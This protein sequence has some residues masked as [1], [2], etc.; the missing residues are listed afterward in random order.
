M[1][2]IPELSG[3]TLKEAAELH[4]LLELINTKLARI[5]QL[6]WENIAFGM[7]H[8]HSKE[9]ADDLLVYREIITQKLQGCG[10]YEQI[11]LSTLVNKIK[12]LTA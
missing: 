4:V 5:G 6:T 2:I 10:C 1:P 12:T 11:K 7:S 3:P 9:Q 8:C